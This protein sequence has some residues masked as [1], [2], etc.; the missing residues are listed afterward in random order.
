MA[1]Y[2]PPSPYPYPIP[3]FSTTDRSELLR[4]IPQVDA[5]FRRFA[6]RHPVPGLAYGIVADGKLIHAEGM[7]I[8]NV[9]DR[10]PVTPDTIFRIASM[11][12]SFTA[13]AAVKLRDEGRLRFDAPAADYVPELASVPYPTR[14]SAPI[15]VRQILTM[16]GGLPQDDPWADRQLAATQEQF[17]IWMREGISFSTPPGVQFEYSNYGYGILGRIVE[18]VSGMSNSAYVTEH[19]LKPLGM[20]SSTFDTT[21][22]P[23]ERFARGYRRE[24]D[25]WADEPPLEDGAFACMGGL[26][27][28]I[29]DFARYMAYLLS[30]Y[31]PRDDEEY[32]PIRRAS[33]REMQQPWQFRSVMST[34]VTP[35]SPA[36]T[37]S[38][39]YGYGLVAGVDSVLGYSV[40]HGGGLPGYGT[41]YRILPYA[42]VGIVAFTNATYAPVRL[43]VND[44]LFHLQK[45]GALKPRTLPASAP[46]LE[47]QDVI[48]RL[49]NHWDDEAVTAI[50]TESFFQDMP[51]EK[52]RQQFAQL[53][54]ALGQ[55]T[56]T[57]PFE[58]E[59]ALRGRW[60]LNCRRGRIEMFI[61][62]TA[63]VPPRVQYLQITAARTPNAALKQAATAL[64][65]LINQWDT[66]QARALLSRGMSP[67][68]LQ[69]QLEA[70]RVLYGKVKAGRVLESDGKTHV[71][72][73]LV[74]KKGEIDVKLVLSPRTGKIREV[75]FTSPREMAFVP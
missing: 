9:E 58:P 29:T 64:T 35:D 72:L 26:F 57:T 24:E 40:N 6:E 41:F 62:M 60:T 16:N 33:L 30:A 18:N 67:A 25:S 32:G 45:R 53:R 66:A 44:A 65:A 75:T 23:A 55:C 17:S 63:T 37:F 42:G 7:G 27:T 43:R 21:S 46:L 61:T 74:G 50:V 8:Q 11:T 14:D 36:W 47:A 22:V 38:D 73:R 51:L 34:R 31:P 2:N 71:R 3:T 54:A 39:G 13:M 49:Y 28:T 69:P 68:A 5:I 15:T 59:N 70:V 56:S 12:K 52:R 4:A 10:T 20:T 19:I 1:T 48:T